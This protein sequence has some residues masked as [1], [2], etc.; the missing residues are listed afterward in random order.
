MKKPT[1]KQAL[2]RDLNFWVD[3]YDDL[4]SDFDSR[5]FAERAISD[6]FIFEMNK[7]TEEK[8]DFIKTIRF[9]IPA[10]VRDE[11]TESVIIERLTKGFLRQYIRFS[12]ELNKSRKNGILMTVL[13]V[14]A[15]MSAAL[16]ITSIGENN[17]WQN[18]LKILFEPA[19]WFLIWTGLDKIFIAQKPIKR[20]RDFYARLEKSKVEFV[21]I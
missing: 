16:T 11:K 19:G 17:L 1:H 21:S 12:D 2:L 5:P 15:L 10:K 9:Q 6:D 8:E 13:G 20:K 4:F 18:F 3:S 7:L 14:V